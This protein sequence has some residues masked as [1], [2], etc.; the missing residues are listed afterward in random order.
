MTAAAD[1]L[2]GRLPTGSF[3]KAAVADAA[4]L[5]T[6]SQ[7]LQDIHAGRLNLLIIRNAFPAAKLATLAERLTARTPP[8]HRKPFPEKFRAWF[9]AGDLDMARPDLTDYDD[10]VASFEQLGPALF[11]GLFSLTDCIESALGAIA[12]GLPVARPKT[13]KGPAYLPICIKEVQSEG[14]IPAHCEN[15]QL[16]RP[17]YQHLR[18]QLDQSTLMAYYAPVQL[19]EGGGELVVYALKW[20]DL[21]PK[22]VTNARSEV[23]GLLPKCERVLVRPQPG[24]LLVFDGGRFF[25]EVAVVRGK[26]TRWTM[27][28]FT[29]LSAARDRVLYWG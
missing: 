6:H 3:L 14:Y 21:D 23:S 28:G 5:S 8:I 10:D 7:S 13:A 18:P 25:H 11:E 17:P 9:L 24:D 20:S 16:L 22:Y 12:G 1:P 29:G 15:E 2:A 26:T 27:G 4:D 19:P